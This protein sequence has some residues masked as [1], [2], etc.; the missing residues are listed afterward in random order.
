MSRGTGCSS[1]A[2][3]AYI[4][5][6]G[7]EVGPDAGSRILAEGGG[8]KGL[9]GLHRGGGVLGPST[10]RGSPA[11]GSWLRR[12]RLLRGQHPRRAPPFPPPLAPSLPAEA[13]PAH[14]SCSSPSGPG[15]DRSRL[16]ASEAAA[17]MLSASTS[18]LNCGARRGRR[19][20][21]EGRGRRIGALRLR[22]GGRPCVVAAR[23]G[24]RARN[25]EQA[26]GNW[27]CQKGG[28]PRPGRP[29]CRPNTCCS[30]GA[31]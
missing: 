30:N 31:S 29:T 19:R 7:P 26:W 17:N 3:R 8:N 25:A 28:G 6:G 4:E 1:V 18:W 2:T 10:I 22:G 16:L 23:R 11:T 5:S 9:G 13:G 27:S 15:Y 24:S 14:S 12:P 20:A 21:E